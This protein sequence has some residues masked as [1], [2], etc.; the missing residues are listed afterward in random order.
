MGGVGH[1]RQGEEQRM[2]NGQSEAQ[3]AYWLP[4]IIFFWFL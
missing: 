2:P 4:A 1:V 3:I